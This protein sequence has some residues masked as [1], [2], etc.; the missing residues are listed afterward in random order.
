[1]QLNVESFED[2]PEGLF[3][4]KKNRTWDDYPDRG[5]KKKRR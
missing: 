1:M 2:M 5:R 3:T 4:P